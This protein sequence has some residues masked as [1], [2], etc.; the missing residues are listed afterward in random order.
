MFFVC[1]VNCIEGN[2]PK[3]VAP[4][5]DETTATDE[6]AASTVNCMG[7]TN[8]RRK[9]AAVTEEKTECDEYDSED[10]DG[11]NEARSF[12][13]AARSS[14]HT[15]KKRKTNVVKPRTS[16]MQSMMVMKTLAFTA[17]PL[18]PDI[19]KDEDDVLNEYAYDT[20]SN[21]IYACFNEPTSSAAAH[22]SEHAH[23]WHAAQSGEINNNFHIHAWKIEE[24]PHNCNL[25]DSKWVFKVKEHEDGHPDAI[26]IGNSW[27]RFRARL[28][29]RGFKQLS[30]RDYGEVFAPVV[31]YATMRM[32]LA[33]A[34]HYGL[35]LWHIDIPKAFTQATLD[36]PCYM[37][38]PTGMKLAAG[39][40]LKLL[41][42]IYGL[43]QGARCFHEFLVTF[44]LSLGFVQCTSDN[45]LF[46]LITEMDFVLICL[47]V[48]DL[49]LG[50]LL[51]LL[52]EDIIKKLE[53]KFDAM[54]MGI[55]KWILGMQ[56]TQSADR[57]TIT[58]NMAK[59]CQNMLERRH[60]DSEKIAA[61][62]M[63]H[64]TKLTSED[65]PTTPHE[66]AAM[67]DYQ[68]RTLIGDL[69][70]LAIC[71][72][73]DIF[74]PVIIC[75]R[76]VSNPG[77]KHY[78]AEKQIYCY[79]KGSINFTIT[80]SRVSQAL[81]PLMQLFTDSDWATTDVDTR[82]SMWGFMA[83]MSGGPIA[84]KS[85]L[86]LL[87][88]SSTEAEYYGLAATSKE[89]IS[90]DQTNEELLPVHN[91]AAGQPINHTPDKLPTTI[92]CDNEATIKVAYNPVLYGR[93]K[94]VEIQMHFIRILIKLAKVRVQKVD[95]EHNLADLMAA[96]KDKRTFKAL[97]RAAC[98]A[99]PP[100]PIILY[101]AE[102]LNLN[103]KI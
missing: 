102:Q 67:A 61:V 11:T 25:L 41:K 68:I 10:D 75:A 55:P 16:F 82:R 36:T 83:M 88:L 99:H 28:V 57:H 72:R 47:Y 86:L 14:S 60:F 100:H 85:K 39:K 76:Y 98:G 17:M 64:T 91:I 5:T 93:L 43:K 62:P 13:P 45:C 51:T 15:S 90:L 84:W 2:N 63:H 50:S 46:Y 53:D 30:G 7:G 59:H 35:H 48:D 4:P 81:S 24:I 96:L 37:R 32:V 9:L 23:H 29:I 22:R 20:A 97:I 8:V 89:A 101:P 54:N 95:G 42:S 74:L 34:A 80:Y 18:M 70:Y 56:M 78:N 27:V 87:S 77:M 52:A 40:C 31:R 21:Y 19:R 79:I 33:I 3:T 71:L 65:C 66:K 38:A 12:R 44:L 92:F 49:L 69:L 1:L 26:K 94:H 58:L 73:F 103:R 6:V